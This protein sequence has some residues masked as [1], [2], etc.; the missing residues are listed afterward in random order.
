M[1]DAYSRMGRTYVTNAFVR[2]VSSFERKHLWITFTLACAIAT[3]VFKCDVK[4]KLERTAHGSIGH[5]LESKHRFNFT[6][7]DISLHQAEITGRP[8][9]L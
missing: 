2:V 6:S 8:I 7:Y 9:E 5:G 1:T 4:V 3:I